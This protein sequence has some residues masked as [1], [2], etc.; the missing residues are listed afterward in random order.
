MA[1]HSA[2]A[3]SQRRIVGPTPVGQARTAA[4]PESRA[5]GTAPR[6]DRDRRPTACPRSRRGSAFSSATKRVRCG[7]PRCACACSAIFSAISTAVEPLSARNTLPKCPG[8][9]PG[10]AAGP[11]A[12]GGRPFAAASSRSHRRTS[13]ALVVFAVM[14]CSNA[15]CCAR[16][17]AASRGW[18]WPERLAPPARDGVEDLAAVVEPQPHAARARHHQRRELDGSRASG[19]TDARTPP[20]R[21]RR[22][23]VSLG[24]AATL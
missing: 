9:R 12:D 2:P 20:D 4:A 5:R 15:S 7:A 22:D 11:H 17:A 19:C 16:S 14:T 24:L 23:R 13:G 10:G 21:G 6:T 18:P 8:R 1:G 3:S